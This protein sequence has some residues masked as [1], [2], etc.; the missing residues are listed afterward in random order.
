M[1]ES[2]GIDADLE[3]PVSPPRDNG[4]IVFAA[5]W[6]RRVFGLTVALCRS[7]ACEWESFRRRLIRRI[8]EDE[9]RAYWKSWAAAL[10]DVLAETSTLDRAELDARQQEFLAR[11]PGDDH[12][13]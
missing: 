7:D 13:H 12:H 1:G 3:G 2:V 6:E 10:E 8:A 11:P 5:P 9:T 4:E